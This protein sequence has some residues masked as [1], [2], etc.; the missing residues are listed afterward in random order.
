M[1]VVLMIVTFATEGRSQFLSKVNI[2]AQPL[3]L[4]EANAKAA[5]NVLMHAHVGTEQ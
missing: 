1:L 4:L 3:S 5:T 2:E